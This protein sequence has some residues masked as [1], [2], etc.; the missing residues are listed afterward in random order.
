MIS[1]IDPFV[2]AG[3]IA[4]SEKVHEMHQHQAAVQQQN[5][6]QQVK[7]DASHKQASV[8]AKTPAEEIVVKDEAGK[9]EKDRRSHHGGHGDHE[10]NKGNKAP[11]DIP[12]V[13]EGRII[14]IKI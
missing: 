14:D 1:P 10:E 8:S 7:E 6:A 4:A 9:H 13:E 3:Q 2:L 11:A 5:L 12:E